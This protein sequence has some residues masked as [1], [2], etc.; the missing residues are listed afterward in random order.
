MNI[1]PY[2]PYPDPNLDSINYLT[3]NSNE[4]ELTGFRLRIRVAIFLSISILTRLSSS[5]TLPLLVLV[6][7]PELVDKFIFDTTGMV[8]KLRHPLLVPLLIKALRRCNLQTFRIMIMLIIQLRVD[9]FE[10]KYSKIKPG[11]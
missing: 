6:D 7:P 5:S 3:Y 8:D 1:K 11:R 9:W 10:P 2:P 4:S